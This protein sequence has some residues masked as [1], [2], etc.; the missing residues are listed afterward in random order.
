MPQGVN[1][2]F[3]LQ[4]VTVRYVYFIIECDDEIFNGHD[5]NQ[6]GVQYLVPHGLTPIRATAQCYCSSMRSD[7]LQREFCLN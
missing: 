5:M 6:Y 4:A 3:N 2:C 1:K 7:T